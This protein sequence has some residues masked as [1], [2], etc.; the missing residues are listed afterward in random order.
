MPQLLRKQIDFQQSR[1]HSSRVDWDAIADGRCYRLVFRQDFDG[2]QTSIQS[3]AHQAAKRLG[4]RVR[5]MR[6]DEDVIVQFVPRELEA[7]S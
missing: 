3:S 5:T 7:T 1:C 4:K 6:D 2:P